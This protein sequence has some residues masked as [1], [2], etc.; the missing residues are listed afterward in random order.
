MPICIANYGSAFLDRSGWP[1]RLVVQRSSSLEWANPFAGGN[2]YRIIRNVRRARAVR[3]VMRW[4]FAVV[5]PTRFSHAVRRQWAFR[6]GLSDSVC[7]FALIYK[8]V[9]YIIIPRC[10]IYS[11]TVGLLS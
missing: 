7:C 5:P 10:I 6:D 3:Q 8:P 1:A 9:Q 4:S 11:S 2:R